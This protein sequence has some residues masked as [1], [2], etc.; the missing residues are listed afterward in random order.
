MLEILHL[1][2]ERF[3][4][5]RKQIIISQVSI[6]SK[7]EL[8]LNLIMAKSFGNKL[9][10]KI[11]LVTLYNLVYTAINSFYRHMLISLSRM[12]KKSINFLLYNK[13]KPQVLFRIFNIR[14]FYFSHVGKIFQNFLSF[15]YRIDRI[16]SLRHHSI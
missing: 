6:K 9:F 8:K 1:H 13:H 4:S 14:I 15:G 12:L 10:E 2:L 5:Y 16:K 7:T 3:Y 11:R